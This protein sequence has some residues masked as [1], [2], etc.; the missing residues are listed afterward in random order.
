MMQSTRVEEGSAE[1]EMEEERPSRREHAAHHALCMCEKMRMTMVR[2]TAGM[3]KRHIR[4]WKETENG[5]ACVLDT[6]KGGKTVSNG[7]AL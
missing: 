5:T 7:V 3:Y 6:K 1:G 2:P 4:L